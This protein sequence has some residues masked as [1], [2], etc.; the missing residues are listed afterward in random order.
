MTNGMS[1]IDWTLWDVDP[2]PVSSN[3]SGR[4]RQLVRDG[5]LL[6]GDRIPAE[7]ALAARLGVSRATVREAL[8]ELELRGLI[9]RTP[10]RGTLVAEIPRPQVY[11]RLIGTMGGSTRVLREVMD[12]R[13]AVEPPIAERAASR[14]TSDQVEELRR[15]IDQAMQEFREGVAR[16]RYIE[17]DVAFHTCLARMTQNAMLERLLAVTHEWMAPSRRTELASDRRIRSS[18]NAHRSIFEAIQRHDATSAR[19]EMALHIEEI[20]LMITPESS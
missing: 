8:Q 6:P 3:I 2:H 13:A 17:L 11:A 14:G 16:E 15:L 20:L 4:I 9:S 19:D 1:L 18:L 10:G 7:R 5:K 12:L